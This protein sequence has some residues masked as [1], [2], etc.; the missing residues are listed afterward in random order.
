LGVYWQVVLP[1][2]SVLHRVSVYMTFANTTTPASSNATSFMTTPLRF[3]VWTP[4]NDNYA[5]LLSPEPATAETLYAWRQDALRSS[6]RA[7]TVALRQFPLALLSPR[8]QRAC[9]TRALSRPARLLPWTMPAY[10]D[11]GVG[12][13]GGAWHPH[14]RLPWLHR[15]TEE[16]QLLSHHEPDGTPKDV[17]TLIAFHIM[18]V[19]ATHT[20]V[21]R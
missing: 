17:T 19:D 13:S 7:A 8:R 16:R 3:K 2:Q 12:I 20:T 18:R 10:A 11:N 21:H 9:Y 6:L 1:K 4:N 14:R 15:T 5:V